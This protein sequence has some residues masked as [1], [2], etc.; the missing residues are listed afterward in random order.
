MASA[1]CRQNQPPA[2]AYMGVAIIPPPTPTPT[3]MVR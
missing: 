3:P 1:R 2:V